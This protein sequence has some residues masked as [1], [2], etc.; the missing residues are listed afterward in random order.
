MKKYT[1]VVLLNSSDMKPREKYV[2]KGLEYVRIFKL[3]DGFDPKDHPVVSKKPA[4]DC[5]FAGSNLR[6]SG[7][8]RFPESKFRYEFI[9]AVSENFSLDAYSGNGKWPFK[10]KAALHYPKFYRAFANSK[11]SL[12]VNHYKL[13]RYYTRRLIHGGASPSLFITAYIPGMEKDFRQDVNMVWFHDIEEGIKKIRYYLNNDQLRKQ[14]AMQQREHFLKYH[15]WEARL[16]EFE[17]IVMELL[18][19]EE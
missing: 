15:S 4:F 6:G 14:V 3:C 2:D 9:K 19:E 5:F 1:D 17:K 12:G 13:N 16:R 7:G 8:W 11:I 10:T 18:E